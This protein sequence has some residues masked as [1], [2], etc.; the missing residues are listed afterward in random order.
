[1]SGLC[2][3][4]VS[5]LIAHQRRNSQF[6]ACGWGELGHSHAAHVTDAVIAAL[7]P[8]VEED[9]LIFGRMPDDGKGK[10]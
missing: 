8:L 10:S 9:G 2:E 7:G 6:C 1:M 5:V 4:I 3:R